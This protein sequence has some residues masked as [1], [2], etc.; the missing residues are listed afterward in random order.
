MPTMRSD[1]IVDASDGDP[2][3]QHC[4]SERCHDNLKKV[5][6]TGFCSAKSMIALTMHI[7]AKAKSL[8]CL[9]LDT[10]RG[11]DRRFIKVDKCLK[12]SKDAFTEAEKAL[13]A[14]RRYVEGR[15]PPAVNLK[16]IEPYSKCIN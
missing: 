11:H 6:I 16:V 4:T 12:L 9:T 2:F 7:V 3:Q 13:L 5:M 15:V 1:S 8:E 10:T 14:I